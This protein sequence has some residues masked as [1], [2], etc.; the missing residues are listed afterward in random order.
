MVATH[1]NV[2]EYLES[3]L[4][5]GADLST[6][7]FDDEIHLIRLQYG[8]DPEHYNKQS[9]ITEDIFKD[10]KKAFDALE[11]QELIEREGLAPLSSEDEADFLMDTLRFPLRGRV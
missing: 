4:D 5:S 11:D 3:L 1:P 8:M 2:Y 6:I 7:S 10:I 9:H